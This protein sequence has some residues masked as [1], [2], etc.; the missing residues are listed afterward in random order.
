MK[1]A[2]WTCYVKLE[3]AIETWHQQLLT[4][5]SILIRPS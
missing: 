4:L 1:N 2:T 5:Y 3:D